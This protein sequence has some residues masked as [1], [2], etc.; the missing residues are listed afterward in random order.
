MLDKNTID[1]IVKFLEDVQE[2]VV[3]VWIAMIIVAIV[4]WYIRN[5]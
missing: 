1:R 5:L 2:F 3:G 4:A